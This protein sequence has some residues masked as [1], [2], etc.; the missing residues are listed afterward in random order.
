[1]KAL[2]SQWTVGKRRGREAVETPVY[3]SSPSFWPWGWG[4]ET[5]V[6]EGKPENEVCR[7][8]FVHK[9]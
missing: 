9:P 8:V 7:N 6:L 4:V 3:M 1:M 5:C 2:C